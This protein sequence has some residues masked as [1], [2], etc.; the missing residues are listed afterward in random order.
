MA[1]TESF[2]RVVA[3]GVDIQNDFCPGGSLAV[4]DGDQIVEL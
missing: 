3:V 1:E 4:P 2:N